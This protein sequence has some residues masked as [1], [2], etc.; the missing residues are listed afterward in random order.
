MERREGLRNIPRKEIDLCQGR[1]VH[2]IES[3]LAFNL[4][5][6][7]LKKFIKN[8]TDIFQGRVKDPALHTVKIQVTIFKNQKALEAFEDWKVPW[9]FHPNPVQFHLYR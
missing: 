3:A 4:K 2:E 1:K 8:T 9:E 6:W 7:N 5:G